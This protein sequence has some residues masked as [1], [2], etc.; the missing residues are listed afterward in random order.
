LK[1]SKLRI[2]NIN[3]HLIFCQSTKFETNEYKWNHSIWDSFYI[4]LV[5]IYRET[6]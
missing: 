4:Y 5:I 3:E 2:Q 6:L 1:E